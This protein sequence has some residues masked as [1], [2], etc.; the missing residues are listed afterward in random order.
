M[1]SLRDKFKDGDIVWAE[2]ETVKLKTNIG[3]V[4]GIHPP[5]GMYSHDEP[6]PDRIL[7]KLPGYT[8]ERAYLPDTECRHAKD[9]EIR[10]YFKDVLKYG[11]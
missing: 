3:V 10:Q 1:A 9:D 11:R 2:W 8:S 7:V 6:L 5:E 4:V